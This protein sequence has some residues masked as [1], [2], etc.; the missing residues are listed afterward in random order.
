[1]H[2]DIINRIYLNESIT[3]N[4]DFIFTDEDRVDRVEGEKK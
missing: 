3:P 1:M 4:F 2:I